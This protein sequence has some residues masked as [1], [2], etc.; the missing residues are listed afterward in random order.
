MKKRI[1]NLIIVDESGSMHCIRKQTINGLNETLQS[2][3]NSQ[4]KH[5]ETENFVTLISFSSEAI[6]NL[7]ENT[8]AGKAKDIAPDNYMPNG[9]TPLYDAIGSGVLKLKKQM[10]EVDS[11]IVTIITDGE[12]NSSTEFNHKKI[13]SLI[14]EMKKK[15]W[16]FSFIGA[17]IDAQ[18]VSRNLNIDYSMQ[19]D[20]SEAGTT[21][22]FQ[23][24]NMMR[25]SMIDC[26]ADCDNISEAKITKAAKRSNF[27]SND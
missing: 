26:L 12:E 17:N 5:P 18:E 10:A 20:Q 15:D 2:I 8:P 21:Y 11:A 14:E 23:A 4:E 3:R 7:Y 9:C 24:N 6:K 13:V 16:V 25:E 19:F 22:M 27:F 1:F